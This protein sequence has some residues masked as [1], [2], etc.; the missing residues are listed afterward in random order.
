MNGDDQ[1]FIV[2]KNDLFV[3]VK[4]II[5]PSNLFSL[6]R[7]SSY[8]CHFSF[9]SHSLVLY[10][11]TCSDLINEAISP[12][13]DFRYR[14]TMPIYAKQPS[15]IQLKSLH[16]YW[17]T[18]KSSH[19]CLS[20][21]SHH[22]WQKNTWDFTSFLVFF[23]WRIILQMFF[24]PFIVSLIWSSPIKMNFTIVSF[25]FLIKKTK[26]DK[27]RKTPNKTQQQKVSFKSIEEK[28]TETWAANY[29]VFVFLIVTLIYSIISL[30]NTDCLVF[31]K[32]RWRLST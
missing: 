31:L 9:E 27:L 26:L 25:W 19:Y 32:I 14:S 1:L 15:K 29:R 21:Y 16:W 13:I 5:H 11:R 24:F 10:I 4:W 30:F 28:L 18:R 23:T 17:D 2:M 20:R 6:S 12:S 3:V 8:R 7:P 22:E